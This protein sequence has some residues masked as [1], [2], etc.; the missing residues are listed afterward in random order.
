MNESAPRYWLSMSLLFAAMATTLV[1]LNPRLVMASFVI[2]L[3]GMVLVSIRYG[4][5]SKSA[6]AKLQLSS[7][8]LSLVSISIFAVCLLIRG[9]EIAFYA[10][11]PFSVA[12]GIAVYLTMKKTN[13]YY[14]EA[15]T[16]M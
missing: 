6:R 14:V 15:R 16:N 9:S 7:P 4:Q 10:A 13:M 11:P 1:L 2:L 5:L 8:A 12:A 3:G